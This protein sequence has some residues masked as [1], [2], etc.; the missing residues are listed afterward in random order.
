MPFPGFKEE[1]LFDRIHKEH[2]LGAGRTHIIIKLG[3]ANHLHPGI[4]Y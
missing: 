2:K 4:S 3:N 1:P